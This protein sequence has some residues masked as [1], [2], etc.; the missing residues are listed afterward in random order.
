VADRGHLPR[1]QGAGGGGPRGNLRAHSFDL[2]YRIMLPLDCVRVIRGPWFGNVP[3]LTG[4]FRPAYILTDWEVSRPIR[5]ASFPA[6]RG[7]G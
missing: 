6:A 3:L 1:W 5:R 7:D 2:A 4:D